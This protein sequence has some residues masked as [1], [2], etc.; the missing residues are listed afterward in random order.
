[1]CCLGTKFLGK[2]KKLKLRE[3][4]IWDWT[5]TNNN[6]VY[7]DLLVRKGYYNNHYYRYRM[8]SVPRTRKVRGGPRQYKKYG[9]LIRMVNHPDYKKYNRVGLYSD[10]KVNGWWSDE[11][12]IRC[13]TK[14]W[15]D[16]KIKK[17]WQKNL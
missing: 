7:G 1:M 13:C 12:N 14:S 9:K 15:K 4:G 11:C 5:P 6:Y 2:T 16:K 3:K 10:L 17:Q 8:D